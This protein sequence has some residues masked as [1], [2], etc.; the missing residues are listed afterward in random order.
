MR[1]G[2]KMFGKATYLQRGLW[3][4]CAAA[5]AVTGCGRKAPA[6]S[7][8]G[9]ASPS[10]PPVEA[11]VWRIAP[12]RAPI[13]EEVV[14]S[15]A[16]KLQARIEAKV[17]GRISALPVD[18]G[19]RVKRGDLI[20]Q[21]DVEEI[22]AKLDAARAQLERASRDLKRYRSLLDQEAVTQAEFDAVQAQY[23]MADAMAREAQTMLGYA[24]VTAPF[25]GVIA[26]KFAD[27]GDLVGPGRPIVQLE[28]PTRLRIEADVPE[29]LMGGVKKGMRLKVTIP[30]LGVETNGVA[31]EIAPAADPMS[32]TFLIK[33][34]L[35][36]IPGLRSGQFGRVAIPYA[37]SDFIRV[38]R[39]AIVQ[40]GQM[41][42]AFV[43]TNGVASMRLVK[44]G[45]R[46]GELVE[47][48]SGLREGED[49][50][51]QGAE[52]LHDGQRVAA[53][54]AGMNAPSRGTSGK[55]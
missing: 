33:I 46:M 27:V 13:V 29:T 39:S 7:A 37:E 35:P 25:D 6:E 54:S 9:A 38:P 8:G 49:L 43:V 50:V 12:S 36:P 55:Q 14:G 52:K 22:R 40:R 47:I 24:R 11:L 21:L 2:V 26:R 41:E 28:D 4:A 5:L 3:A 10:L 16:P 15:I 45:K 17:N 51:V 30:S 23:R 34:D 19:T 48:L 32:R 18:V 31:A 44:T 53:R 1:E 42:T 20:A